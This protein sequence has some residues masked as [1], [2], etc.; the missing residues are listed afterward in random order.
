MPTVLVAGGG[1]G[2]HIFP[3]VAIARELM[4][5]LPGCEVLFVG[6]ERGL[7]TKIVP[8]E[9]F[10]LLTIRSAGITGKRLGARLKGMALIPWSL[11]QSWSLIGQTRPA[12]VIGVGG[13]AS[14]PVLAAAVLRRVPTLIHEQNFVPGVTNRW[15]AP[16]VKEVAV[17]FPETVERLGGR[18]EVTGNPVR[19]EFTTVKPKT[20]GGPTKNLLVLGGSQGARVINRAVR[21]ALP[22]LA[23][24]AGGPGALR[25]AH[26]TGEAEF[27]AVADA[28]RASGLD[29]ADCDV[30]PF[31]GGRGGVG[32]MARALETADL[33][34]S[35]CGSTT[36][37]ELTVAGRPAVLVPFAAAT[38]DHQTFNARKL[39]DAGAA[40]VI[41]EKD[42]DGGTLADAVTALLGDPPRMAR[43]SE[44]SRALG[45]PDAASRIADLCLRLVAAGRAA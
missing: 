14:G 31:I 29:P 22:R 43:M 28:Y 37:A 20:A 35:R 17:T 6:T 2:G 18:G 19:K 24:F 44:A 5:R 36:L 4:Q 7:E 21:E 34:V 23:A 15:L 11:A 38:H 1:T 41:A 10:R 9:G 32:E 42:L 39:A 25:I 26:Q 33:V 27:Q 8:A 40:V 12:L 30:R 13:Y 3:G 45:R 16:F